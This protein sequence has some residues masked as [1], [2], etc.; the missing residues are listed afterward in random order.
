MKT[1]KWSKFSM[2]LLGIIFVLMILPGGV[3]AVIVSPTDVGGI[4]YYDL[5]VAGN[6]AVI[7]DAI[8]TGGETHPAGS[9]V[10]GSFLRS[11]KDEND[12]ES[13]G[14]NTD[15][16]NPTAPKLDLDQI[17]DGNFTRSLL[18]SALQV[19]DDDYYV[20]DLDINQTKSDPY[21]SLDTFQIY[22]LDDPD[23]YPLS[24]VLGGALV[25]DMDADDE[26]AIKMNYALSSSGSGESD[27]YVYVEKKLFDAAY[28]TG[29]NLDYVYLFVE[30]GELD[31]D[32]DGYQEWS[33]IV[34]PN[35]LPPPVPEPATFILL[36]GGLVGLALYRRRQKK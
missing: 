6:T 26:S 20:F 22:L 10:F 21:L 16:R 8:F 1:L 19:V 11:G 5:T 12:G 27:I 29:V 28:A 35:D 32:N 31:G 3:F 4:D 7:D 18:L 25:Y 34:G 30:Y 24:S 14:Y 17:T 33:A 36:G 15:W 23:E 9:G 2:L 13:S